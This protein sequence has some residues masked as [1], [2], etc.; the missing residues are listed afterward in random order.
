MPFAPS[1]AHD[2]TSTPVQRLPWW[3]RA[4]SLFALAVQQ[5]S[6]CHLEAEAGCMMQPDDEQKLKDEIQQRIDELG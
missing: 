5:Q 6:V 2:F 4:A 3:Q 1:Q